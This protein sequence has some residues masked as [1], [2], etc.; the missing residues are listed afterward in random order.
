MPE[1]LPETKASPFVFEAESITT[2]EIEASSYSL[3]AVLRASYKL[4][5]RLFSFILPQD[6]RTEGRFVVALWT[7]RGDTL[8]QDLLGEFCRELADQ[9]LR[10]RLA[11]EAADIGAMIVAQAFAEGNLLEPGLDD[12]DYRTDPR[13]IADIR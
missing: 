5:D 4:S 2:M 13:G 12:D 7:R 1:N 10:V 3:P 9:E 6:S 8:S 11:E